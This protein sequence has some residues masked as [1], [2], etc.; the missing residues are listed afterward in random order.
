MVPHG[1]IDRL[2][3]KWK[4]RCYG[5]EMKAGKAEK[6]KATQIMVDHNNGKMWH[7]CT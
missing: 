4:I 1:T 2:T 7:K 3:G 6:L 5:V